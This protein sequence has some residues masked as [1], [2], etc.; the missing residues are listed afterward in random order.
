MA[1]ITI[2][3][4]LE[5]GYNKFL[6][7]HLA[8]RR[9][10]QLRKGKDP[11]VECN[12]R[13]IVT[14]LREI[15]QGRVRLRPEADLSVSYLQMETELPAPPD[16]QI[17]PGAAVEAGE[18]SGF[19]TPL[20][21]DEQG[22]PDTAEEAGAEGDTENGPEEETEVES[23]VPGNETDQQENSAKTE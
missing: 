13:E 9:V 16:D 19:E 14:S 23:E 6:L 22:R 1:R 17:E 2:E 20:G 5:K 3:E 7:V 15:E 21:G 10:V 4:G 11:L 8:A 12:N 18:E